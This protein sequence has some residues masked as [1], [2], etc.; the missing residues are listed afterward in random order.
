LQEAAE[1]LFELGSEDRLKVLMELSRAPMKL[2]VLAQNLSTTIQEATRQCG[3]LENA[4][5]VQK[6]P[7]GKYG[8]TTLGRIS[9]ALLPSFAL[10]RQ[11]KEYFASHDVTTLPLEFIERM[12]ELLKHERI[13]HIDDALKFQQRVVKE[14]EKFVWFMSDQPVGHSFHPEH[15]HFSPQTNLR[16]ILPKTVD[17]DIFRSAKNLMGPRFQVGLLDEVKLV[18]AMNEKMSAIGLPTF[19]GRID[20]GRGLSGESEPF[21]AWCSDLFSHY[22]KNATKKYPEENPS[23]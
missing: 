22:W 17:T 7:D 2:S 11:E 8:L 23:E 16:I 5:L 15:A 21:M 6:Q 14:S 13:D 18:L 4:A 19:D 1:L 10:L 20:Y 3:R 9:L 12:G